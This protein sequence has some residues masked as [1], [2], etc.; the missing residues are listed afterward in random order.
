MG[1]RSDTLRRPYNSA[2]PCLLRHACRLQAKRSPRAFT[3]LPC[4][5][6]RLVRPDV[7][8]RRRAP[9]SGLHTNIHAARLGHAEEP[10]N[11][12]PGHCP[13]GF[14][15]GPP[16]QEVC[17][18]MPPVDNPAAP[19]VPDMHQISIW[20]EQRQWLMEV[21]GREDIRLLS[22]KL[23]WPSSP[24]QLCVRAG[25]CQPLHPQVCRG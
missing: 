16:T 13:V 10:G 1:C 12:G 7:N 2:R 3:G 6:K 22:Q 25:C 17:Q 21:T 15:W 5:S 11:L 24:T 19:F 8:S 20:P 23:H 4:L 18:G 9:V 14:A